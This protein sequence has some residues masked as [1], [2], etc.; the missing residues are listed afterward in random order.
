MVVVTYGPPS[1]TRLPF[2]FACRTTSLR[3]SFCT[4][5]AVANTMSAHSISEAFNFWTFKSTSLRSHDCGSKADTVSSPSGGN[6]QRFPSNGSACRKL[7]YVSGNSGLTNKTF[8]FLR[9]RLSSKHDPQNQSS[10]ARAADIYQSSLSLC[11]DVMANGP[12]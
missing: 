1:T 3:D 12:T 2:A 7:Q 6:A 4:N 10:R 5:I 11:K 9:L 8:I